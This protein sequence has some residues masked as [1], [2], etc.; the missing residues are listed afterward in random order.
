MAF[1]DLCTSF[2]TPS[3]PGRRFYLSWSV[4]AQSV[5][6][7]GAA[8][9]LHERTRASARRMGRALAKPITLQN[10]VMGIAALHPCYGLP[11]KTPPN[12]GRRV[13]LCWYVGAQSM[14]CEGAADQLSAP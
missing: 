12:S 5:A 7:E 6:C 14:A 13:Y 2:K 4:G 10:H 9:Q 3:N 8:D 1:N 11:L